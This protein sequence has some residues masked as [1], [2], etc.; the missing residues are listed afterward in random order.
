M[1]SDKYCL[2]AITAIVL[3]WDIADCRRA[4]PIRAKKPPLSFFLAES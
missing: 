2:R 4:W 1:I 3:H